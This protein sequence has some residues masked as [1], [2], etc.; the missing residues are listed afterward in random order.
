MA[1][2]NISLLNLIRDR[3]EAQDIARRMKGED[4]F[5][6]CILNNRQDNHTIT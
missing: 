3:I 2:T 4:I 6:I 5:I 1:P